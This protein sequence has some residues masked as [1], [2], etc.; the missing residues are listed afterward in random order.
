LTD[1]GFE[2]LDIVG[3]GCA[4]VAGVDAGAPHAFRLLVRQG[5]FELY[6]ND[7]LVQ[8]YFLNEHRDGTLALLAV[9]ATA[10]FTHL[11]AWQMT[12]GDR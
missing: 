5:L 9:G 3:P 6:V 7:L 10:E 4:S 12:I 8:T 1:R 11:R 2:A